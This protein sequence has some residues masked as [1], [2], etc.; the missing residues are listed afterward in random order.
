MHTVER[1]D[2]VMVSVLLPIFNAAATVCSAV[3]SILRQTHRQ[4]EIVAVDDGSTDET[5]KLLAAIARRDARVKVFHQENSGI[6]AALNYG[7]SACHGDY[8]A[9]MDADDYALPWRLTTQLQ[10]MM[11]AP[12][13]AA[14]GTAIVPFD[15]RTLRP[16]WPQRFPLARAGI[17]TRLLFNPPIMHPTAMMR[18]DLIKGPGFYSRKSP[19]AEDFELWSRLVR[20]QELGNIR[21]VG[22]LYRRS[23]TSI[24]G[25]R[26]P[27]QSASADH[28]RIANL[29]WLLGD[30]FAAAHAAV[31]L[32]IMARRHAPRDLL[33]AMPEYVALLAE[34]PGLDPE[35]IAD[36][37]FGYCLSYAR[38]G[39]LDAVRLY[40]KAGR[41][42]RPLRLLALCAAAA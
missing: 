20:T 2:L 41:L 33:L 22:L 29:A 42:T 38:A 37:W 4:L 28:L 27:E 17:L 21:T 25:S 32:E 30:R 9:R 36:H 16:G 31:H 5:P 14:C 18:R 8:V 23:K 13:I 40:R 39:G 7:L 3:Q 35:V 6:V 10:L 24:T 12:N 26:R 19:H 1:T 11:S 34:C 15:N